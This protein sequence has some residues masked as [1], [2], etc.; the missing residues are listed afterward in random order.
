M[1]Y[2][3]CLVNKLLTTIFNMKNS[4]LV[5]S[6]IFSGLSMAGQNSE[7]G[8]NASQLQD[9]TTS[10]TPSESD[11]AVHNALAKNQIS[12]LALNQ[13]RL[14]NNDSYFSNKVKTKG[15]SNQKS[16]G[17]CWLFT[18][19]NV[20]RSDMI[21]NL[22]LPEFQLSQNFNFFWDML[23][24]SNLFLQS[25][26][27]SAQEPM[28]NRRV[29]WL[30]R[31]PIGD[32]GQFTGIIDIVSKYGVV[33][34]V[35][36][37]ETAQSENTSAMRGLLSQKLR[38]WGLR[39]RKM[40][41]GGADLSQLEA[42]KMKMLKE[43]YRFLALNLGTPPSSFEWTRY[44]SKGEPVETKTY[45]P[46]EYYD[47][48]IGYDLK[49]GYVMM[50]NDPS[51]P[52]WEVYEIDLDRHVYDGN[53]WKFVNVPMDIIK[54]TAIASLKD[55]TAL[56]FS[57]DVGKFIDRD[58]GYLDLDTY[59]YEDLFGMSFP[60]TKA[61]RIATGAS[62][63]THAMTLS[64]VDLD[65]NGKPKKWLVENSWGKGANDG[66]LYMT[67]P[68]MDEY[69]F[70]LVAEK[71]YVPKK[72]TDTLKKKTPIILPPWDILY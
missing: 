71:Q 53:N 66:Y 50:M 65:K 35:V 52:Y 34:A 22:D 32:G 24:K 14:K 67:D 25:V 18:G 61:E 42:E 15:I 54:E 10:Y 27:D 64:G 63:S 60:M 55:S 7:G 57:C 16:S 47:T 69:L 36:M 48:M 9:I 1:F 41:A 68:W 23:E 26:I 72:V 56:Y 43:T 49:D 37:P 70:R 33:P 59:D 20:M 13:D 62:A 4:L 3:I 12:N 31:N 8:I 40:A 21:S 39:L 2:Y 46:K 6:L 30:F 51:R 45:T 28:D 44:N 29:E 5:M 19:L 17:R 38:E 58:R 11:K